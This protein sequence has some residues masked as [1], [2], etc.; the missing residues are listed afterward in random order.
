[1]LWIARTMAKLFETADRRALVGLHV[2]HCEQARD[3]QN[4]VHA[5]G[6]VQK[7]QFTAG[8]FHRGVGAYE[9]AD[10]G[11]IDVIHVVKAQDDLLVPCVDQISDGLAQHGAAF[12]ERN[13]A[14]EI[15]DDDVA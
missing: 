2:K 9:F 10:P 8:V 15:N 6:K 3:L 11:A 4:V 12:A 1:M 13:L 5:F 14:A 7:L